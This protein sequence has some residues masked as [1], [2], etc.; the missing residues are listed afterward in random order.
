[1]AALVTLAEL[2]AY[3]TPTP[4]ASNDALLQEL[5]DNVQA[6]FESE[7]GRQFVPFVAEADGVTEVHDGNGSRELWLDY[8]I[9]AIT[10]VKLGYD[11][12]N[13]DE[14]LA[15][16]DKKVLVFGIGDRRIT[17]TDGGTFGCSAD[18]AR[19]YVQVVYDHQGDMPES[20]KLAVKSVAA[21]AFGRRGTEVLQSET[22][23]NY[24][25][26]TLKEYAEEATLQDPFWQ[27]G[28]NASR[29]VVMA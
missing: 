1:M 9:D 15:A 17:R 4:D 26:R 8:P 23:G 12:A 5:L 24:Y 18:I 21:T 13:P 29:L 19:R 7:A 3:I 27:M 2:K 20:G 22:V 25:T 28:V 14:I 6:L 11:P 16:S 10:S